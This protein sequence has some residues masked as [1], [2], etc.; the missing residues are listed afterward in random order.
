MLLGRAGQE[1]EAGEPAAAALEGAV[2]RHGGATGLAGPDLAL[3]LTLAP[4]LGQSGRADQVR[5]L[6]RLQGELAVVREQARD[7]AA[8]FEPIC[9][10]S[11]LLAGLAVWLLLL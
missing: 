7:R 5:H 3:L 4:V 2:A 8:R 10:Y 6:S 9:R 11:G 1:I